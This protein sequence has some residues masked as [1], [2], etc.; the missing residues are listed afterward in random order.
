MCDWKSKIIFSLGR[1]RFA[2][3][4]T[5]PQNKI[6][7][8]FCTFILNEKLSHSI[9]IRKSSFLVATVGRRTIEFFTVKIARNSEESLLIKWVI[10]LIFCLP[11]LITFSWTKLTTHREISSPTSFFMMGFHATG[12]QKSEHMAQFILSSFIFFPEF[13]YFNARTVSIIRHGN[14]LM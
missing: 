3:D 7:N 2:T 8:G 4:P 11:F 6:R 5:D 10:I 14:F 12:T 9:L 1:V 13:R